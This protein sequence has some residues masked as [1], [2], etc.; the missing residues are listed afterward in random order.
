VV[1][2]F[3]NCLC[4]VLTPGQQA[5]CTRWPELVVALPTAVGAVVADRTYDTSVVLSTLTACKAS[6]VIPA[7]ST[8]KHPRS[9]DRNLYVDRNKV[10]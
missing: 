2:A 5:D 3:G 6:S 4:L 8:R 10:E 1:D 7:K 9:H